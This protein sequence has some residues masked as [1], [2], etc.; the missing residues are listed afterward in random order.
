MD[1]KQEKIT[2][3]EITRKMYEELE[4]QKDK[5]SEEDY[6]KELEKIDVEDLIEEFIPLLKDFFVGEFTNLHNMILCTFYNGEQFKI[7]IEKV[8][9]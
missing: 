3:K 5:M 8:E 7:S 2:R 1:N 4:K 6:E 9:E